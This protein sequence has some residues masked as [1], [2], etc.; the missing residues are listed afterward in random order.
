MTKK[1]NSGV[2]LIRNTRNGKIYVGS[3]HKRWLRH[4]SSLRRGD[5]HSK[6]LQ[7][8]WDKHGASSFKF[9]IVERVD[10]EEKLIAHEQTHLDNI[11]PYNRDIGYNICPVAGN[12][13][14]TTHTEAAKQK[15]REAK[16]GLMVGAKNPMYGVD[17][18]AEN[19]PSSKL[20]WEDVRG[21]RKQYFSGSVSYKKLS[22]IYDTSESNIAQIIKNDTWVDNEYVPPKTQ[23]R[24]KLSQKNVVEIRK[25][26][27]ESSEITLAKLAEEF[28]VSMTNIHAIV[29]GRSWKNIND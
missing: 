2:Y 23:K 6:H 8:A 4:K 10:N 21:I 19:N 18:S 26:Y 9:E 16:L 27:A 29:T 3:T 22:N 5:H 24:R 11:T 12:S 17:M 25:R 1:T 13:L 14:G 15:M 28:G 7:R 20:T